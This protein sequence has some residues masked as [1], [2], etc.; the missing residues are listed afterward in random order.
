MKRT[1]AS[2]L[3]LIVDDDAVQRRQIAIYLE[4]SGIQ[5][6]EAEDGAAAVDM[7]RSLQPAI[8]I[9]D[10]L[11]PK[12]DGIQVAEAVAGLHDAK[13]ILMTGDTD[14]LYRANVSRL[15]IFATIEKPVPLKQLTQFVLKALQAAR[16]SSG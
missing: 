2:Q 9:M 4:S 15:K 5:T 7:I 3:V 14:S 12:I 6:A 16:D 10:I 1:C 13:I 8:V 11:M